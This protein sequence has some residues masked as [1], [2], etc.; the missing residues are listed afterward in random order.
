MNSLDIL[1]V[2][3]VYAKGNSGQTWVL[4]ASQPLTCESLV[5]IKVLIVFIC[6]S[7]ILTPSARHAVNLRTWS[8]LQPVQHW[9]L[10]I[11][12]TLGPIYVSISACTPIRA[13][14][15]SV[16]QLSV[17][18]VGCEPHCW[19]ASTP[20]KDHTPQRLSYTQRNDFL[21]SL[22]YFCFSLRWKGHSSPVPVF[23]LTHSVRCTLTYVAFPL[24]HVKH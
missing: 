14:A 7:C 23:S 10:T 2:C 22:R 21:L 9:L 16:G 17:R 13:M 4:T 20:S 1:V 18:S 15:V 11:S 24:Q 5:P 19:A 6:W 8:R 12:L 3:I